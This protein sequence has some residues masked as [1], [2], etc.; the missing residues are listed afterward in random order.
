[1]IVVEN[2][3]TLSAGAPGNIVPG[4][5]ITLDPGDTAADAVLAVLTD[6]RLDL[7]G[8]ETLPDGLRLLDELVVRRNGFDAQLSASGIALDLADGSRVEDAVVSVEIQV[9]IENGAATVTGAVEFTAASARLF[10]DGG[11][12]AVELAGVAGRYEIPGGLFTLSA[13][14]VTLRIGEAVLI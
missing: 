13:Q 7:D 6:L 8:F 12:V 2:S 4:V 9:T 14:A 3:F 5:V 11:V 10:D 1:V